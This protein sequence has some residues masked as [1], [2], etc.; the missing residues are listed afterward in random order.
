MTFEVND[1]D[2]RAVSAL[3]KLVEELNGNGGILLVLDD[4]WGWS[5]IVA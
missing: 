3:G 2:S 5:G 1:N 4:V